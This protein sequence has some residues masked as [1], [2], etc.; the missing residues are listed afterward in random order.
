MAPVLVG[1]IATPQT[2]GLPRWTTRAVGHAAGSGPAVPED[3]SGRENHLISSLGNPTGV[4]IASRAA[5]FPRFTTLAA[6]S[7]PL[8][9]TCCHFPA[10]GFGESA[11][12]Q[13]TIRL[14]Y[15]TSRSRGVEG[16]GYVLAIVEPLVE[17]VS[18]HR[19]LPLRRV[20]GVLR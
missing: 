14:R 8:L 3:A 9:A 12:D 19:S 18:F 2:K 7:T 17:L 5:Q 6:I 20:S 13:A 16:S 1:R 10:N 4:E 11:C 15:E